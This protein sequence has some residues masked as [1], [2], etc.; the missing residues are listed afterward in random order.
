LDDPDPGV[1][2]NDGGYRMNAVQALSFANSRLLYTAT[3]AGVWR[4]ERSGVSTWTKR[5]LP[6]TGLPAG[7]RITDVEV[8]DA[9][10][11]AVYVTIAGSASSHVYYFPGGGATRWVDCNLTSR[12]NSL[13]SPA[14]AVVVDPSS[15]TTLYVATDVGVF[16][17]LKT[18]ATTWIWNPFSQGLPQAAVVDL[19]IHQ[20]TRLLRAAT[21][22]RGMW[23]ILLDPPMNVSDTELY[24]RVNTADTGRLTGGGQR[25]SWVEGHPDPTRQGFNVY[26]WMSPDIRVRRPSLAAPPVGSPPNFYDFTYNVGD[27]VDTNNVETIDPGANR[28]F[29]QVHNRGRLPIDGSDLRV[30]LLLADAHTGLP[31]MPANYATHI[32][33]GDDPSTWVVP[34]SN[35]FIGDVISPYQSAV[36]S[37][38]AR[39]SGVVSFNID[40]ASLGLPATH[41]HICT[42]AFVTSISNADRLNAA[43]P[44]LDVLTMQDRHVVYRNLHV[45]PAGSTLT[46]GGAA[47]QMFVFDVRNPLPRK[48]T[49]TLELRCTDQ[50]FDLQIV[51]PRALPSPARRCAVC[52]APASTSAP[53]RPGI[54]GARPSI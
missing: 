40:V 14:H 29:V 24:M 43:E 28:V 15:S 17:G 27:Y 47:P 16:Q 4:F 39:V 20:A 38:D 31:A 41:D 21:H 5:P 9:A 34:S 50:P 26:H 1:P 18:G 35:W 36:G 2:I 32:V 3:G 51:A 22:G 54:A 45:V 44:S 46:T 10:A 52:A 8:A 49:Y 6:S 11:G 23:E 33:A 48:T 19:A 25:Y 13:D 30:L 37:V 12:G 7:R 42:T 53:V